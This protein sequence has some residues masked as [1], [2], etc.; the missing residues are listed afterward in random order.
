[1]H[2]YVLFGHYFI[3]IIGLF[4]CFKNIV[5]AVIIRQRGLNIMYE[6]LVVVSFILLVLWGAWLASYPSSVTAI[7]M[8]FSACTNLGM[9]C[10]HKNN[11]MFS[12]LTSYIK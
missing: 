7:N 8:V 12:K 6:E 9:L 4:L 2:N 3:M 10:M 1:M 5:F 11:H